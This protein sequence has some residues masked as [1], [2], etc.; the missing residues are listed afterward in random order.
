ML[1]TPEP[2]RRTVGIPLIVTSDSVIVGVLTLLIAVHALP[3]YPTALI[4]YPALLVANAMIIW[5]ASHRRKGPAT[6]GTRISKLALFGA[7]AFTVGC[8]VQ[9]VYWI[10]EPNLRSTIQVAIGTLL[11][12]YAW[13]LVHRLSKAKQ[14]QV[15]DG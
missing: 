6:K 15:R 3:L 12:A 4:A 11:A 14:D 2:R 8:I 13:F 7:T 9:I 10:I 1:V 5:T